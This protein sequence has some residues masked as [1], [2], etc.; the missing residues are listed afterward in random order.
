MAHK[1]I[2]YTLWSLFNKHPSQRGTFSYQKSYQACKAILKKYLEKHVN[3]AHDRKWSY[4]CPNSHEI[5]C[6]CLSQKEILKKTFWCCPKAIEKFSGKYVE[7]YFRGGYKVPTGWFQGLRQN[8]LIL[9]WFHPGSL[10]WKLLW[11][12]LLTQNWKTNWGSITLL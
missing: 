1:I 5:F 9:K 12:H 2:N 11:R 4:N 3:A 8:D 7:S 6:F 10:L